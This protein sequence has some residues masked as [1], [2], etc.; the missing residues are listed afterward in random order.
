MWFLPHLWCLFIFSYI[1]YHTLKTDD[2]PVFFKIILVLLLLLAG[3]LFIIKFWHYQGDIGGNKFRLHG[4]PFSVDFLLLSAAYFLSG[5][6]L[7]MRIIS[8]KPQFVI[9]LLSLLI[10]FPIALLTDTRIDLNSRLYAGPVLATCAAICGI[11]II[12]SLSFFIC[13]YELLKKVFVA[14]GSASLFILIFHYYISGKADDFFRLLMHG[15][16]PFLSAA[17]EFIA[18][19]TLPLLVRKII[20]TNEFFKLF[21]FPL[22]DNKLILRIRKAGSK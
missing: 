15:R 16:Y 1:L 3:S 18:C 4:L 7:K 14:F 11:Y 2:W 21:Y 17:I 6:F 20:L 10:F 12:L 22:K 5:H 13:K 8:F 19:I 9:L